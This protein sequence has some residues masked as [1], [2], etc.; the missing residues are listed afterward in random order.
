M[1]IHLL[2]I[3]LLESFELAELSFN[4]HSVVGD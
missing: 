3:E 4:G 2:G 1:V